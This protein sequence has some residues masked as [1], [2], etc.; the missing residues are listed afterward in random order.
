[1]TVPSFPPGFPPG[2]RGRTPMAPYDW[3]RAPVRA[4]KSGGA[5]C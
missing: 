3:C 2:H 4:R 5:G 1:M